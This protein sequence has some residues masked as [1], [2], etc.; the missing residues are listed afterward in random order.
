MSGS[1]PQGGAQRLGEAQGVA[2]HFPLV[3]Q[4]LLGFVHEFDRVLDGED[5]LVAA[6]VDVVHHRRQ[7]GGFTRAGGP[8][9]QHDAAREIGYLLEH[10]AHAQILHG[11]HLG[12]NGPEHGAGAPVLVEGVDP[13]AGHAGHVEGEV[14]LQEFL[15]ILA[16]L[17]VHD[18]INERVHFLVLHGRQIDTADVAVHPDHRGQAGGKVQIR[19]AVFGAEGKQFGDIHGFMY[20]SQ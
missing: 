19:G 1:S 9:Y 12:G 5:V 2:V 20:S 11:Q 10:L 14:G 13:E 18:V 8:G 17:V 3:D 15:V 7:G 16:L 4:A 6:F